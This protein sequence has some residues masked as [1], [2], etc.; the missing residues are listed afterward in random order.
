MENKVAV[1]L[2][3]STQEQSTGSQL[4]EITEYLSARNWTHVKVYEDKASGTTASR[5][6]LKQLLA[7]A[8]E[9][10]F[11]VVVCF[12]LDRFFR[13]LKDLV[14]TLQELTEIGVAFI[15]LK[16]HID[17]ST[18]SGRLMMH[19]LGAFAEFEASLIRERVRAGLK[20]ARAKGKKLGRPRTVDPERVLQ[21]R[22]RGMSLREI[23][24][25]LNTTKSSVSKTLSREALNNPVQKAG[26][27]GIA[28]PAPP[29]G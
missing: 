21:L 25:A 18:S 13:S 26:I 15:S 11:D 23:A 4:M 9:R 7:D 2:R 27:I 24:L 22:N 28:D 12:K 3:V 20:N 19:L 8:R 10:K 5:P 17:L 6:M 1:Y 14:V 16:D 29:V